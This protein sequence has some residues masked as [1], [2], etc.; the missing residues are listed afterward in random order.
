MFHLFRCFCD[1][2]CHKFRDCCEDAEL[3]GCLPENG[4]EFVPMFIAC[5]TALSLFQ[6]S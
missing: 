1:A 4:V 3:I 2:L 6:F 5:F